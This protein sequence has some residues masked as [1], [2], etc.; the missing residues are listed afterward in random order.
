ATTDA[1]ALV[2]AAGGAAV[3][4]HPRSVKR[5][6]EVTDAQLA[7]LAEAGLAGIE[8]EHPEQPPE[9]RQRLREVA[10]ELGLAV[11]GSSDFHGD[12]KPVRLGQVATPAE[13]LATL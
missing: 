13:A 4:A 1:I 7:R 5:R 8:A 3:L 2:R 6:A 10:A 11:T 9:V 12:R